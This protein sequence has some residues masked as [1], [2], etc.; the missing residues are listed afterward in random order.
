MSKPVSDLSG[1]EREK[2]DD[3]LDAVSENLGL[4]SWKA[5]SGQRINWIEEFV[6]VCSTCKCLDWARKEF[7]GVIAFCNS[8]EVRLSGKERTME[9]N[10]HERVGTMTLRDMKEMAILIDPPARKIGF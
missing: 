8:F 3:Q 9:C 4:D 7:G 2:L 1:E 10:R 6:G 5:R